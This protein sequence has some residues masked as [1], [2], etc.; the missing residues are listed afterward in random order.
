MGQERHPGWRYNVE[1]NPDVE[2]QVRG[3]RYRARASVLS[4]AEKDRYWSRIQQAIPQMR[5]YESRTERNIRV[6][7]LRR[8]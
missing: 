4:D 6:F 5:T 2:L 1:A 3:E 7:R 8:S